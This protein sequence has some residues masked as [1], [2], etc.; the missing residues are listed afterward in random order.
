MA[1]PSTSKAADV[2]SRISA[3]LSELAETSSDLE[4]V[5]GELAADV[6]AHGLQLERVQALDH[7]TQR[8]NALAGFVLR[9]APELPTTAVI[10]VGEA[11]ADLPLKDLADRLCGRVRAVDEDQGARSGDF[12][13]L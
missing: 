3:E 5:V 2:L 7:L 6:R 9:I 8:L 12:E 4:A 10:D 13:L 1:S 11:A